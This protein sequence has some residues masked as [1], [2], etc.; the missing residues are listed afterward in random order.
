[1]FHWP[2]FLVFLKIAAFSCSGETLQVVVTNAKTKTE[3][4]VKYASNDSVYELKKKIHAEFHP[5]LQDFAP[6]ALVLE[7][8]GTALNHV[9][10]IFAEV[11]QRGKVVVKTAK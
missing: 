1:M 11:C 6:G 3:A 2:F 9:T 8:D 4:V 10:A 7:C 5:E